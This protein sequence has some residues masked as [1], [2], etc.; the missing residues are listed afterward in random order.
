MPEIETTTL[1]I[2]CVPAGPGWNIW[3]GNHMFSTWWRVV[4][5]QGETTEV[6]LH[7]DHWREVN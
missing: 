5:H 6:L 2:N 4:R 1:P 7:T 3:S